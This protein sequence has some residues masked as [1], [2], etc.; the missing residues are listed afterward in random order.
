M[1]YEFECRMNKKYKAVLILLSLF[2]SPFALADL[3]PSTDVRF[4]RPFETEVKEQ[5]P[6]KTT[7]VVSGTC[8]HRSKLD[9]RSDALQCKTSN[10]VLDPCFIKTYAK[11][12]TAICPYSPWQSQAIIVHL[13]PPLPNAITNNQDDLDMSED[14]PWAINLVNDVNCLKLSPNNTF[15]VHGQK[16]KYACD[17]HGFL[18]GHIQRCNLLWKMLFLPSRESNVLKSVEISAAW[19]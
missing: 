15:S 7:E 10:R 16:V 13:N 4:Y 1:Q 6:L 18:L 9:N 3:Q 19:Y 17:N 2:V 11:I 5:A 12:K 8:L 14:D